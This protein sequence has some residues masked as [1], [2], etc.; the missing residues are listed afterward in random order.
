MP[1]SIST[2]FHLIYKINY[3]VESLLF[4]Q[5]DYRKNRRQIFILLN[6]K[7]CALLQ[8]NGARRK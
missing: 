5:Y 1:E 3:I 2:H 8:A 4:K 7:M 6:H